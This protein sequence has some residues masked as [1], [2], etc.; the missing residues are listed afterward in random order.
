[1]TVIPALGRLRQ[2]CEFKASLRG[3]ELSSKFQANLGYI[4]ETLSQNKNK[5]LG[6]EE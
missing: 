6:L 2:D 1:M 4:S 3:G 5:K